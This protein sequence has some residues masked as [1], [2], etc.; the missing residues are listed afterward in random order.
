M[1]PVQRSVV[2]GGKRKQTGAAGIS[3]REI[4]SRVPVTPAEA[5]FSPYDIPYEI[6][7]SRCGRPYLWPPNCS[8]ACPAPLS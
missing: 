1:R 7:H 5:L 3:Q 6:V 8:V 2:A 4:L